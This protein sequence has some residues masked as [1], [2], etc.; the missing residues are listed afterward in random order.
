MHIPKYMGDITKRAYNGFEKYYTYDEMLV[1]LRDPANFMSVHKGIM[2][3]LMECLDL[4]V[5]DDK[6]VDEFKRTV[7]DYG[8]TTGEMLGF[9]TEVDAWF[10][11]SKLPRRTWAT[12]LCFAFHLSDEEAGHFLWKVCKLNGFC[13]RVAEDVIHCY[14]LANGKSYAEAKDI[15]SEYKKNPKYTELQEY[16]E[17]VLRRIKSRDDNYTVRTGE[18]LRAFSNL[19]GMDVQTFKKALFD[20]SKYFIGYSVSAHQEMVE[21]YEEAVEQIKKDR[22]VITGLSDT[23]EIKTKNENDDDVIKYRTM[24]FSTNGKF[25]VVDGRDIV[26][27]KFDGKYEF[28]YDLVW[29]WLAETST[30]VGKEFKHETRPLK[31]IS[32]V[33]NHVQMLVNALPPV[34]RVK[35]LMKTSRPE[36]AT[37]REYGSARMVFV[38]LYF[39]QFVLRWERYL[40]DIAEQGES[41]E[42]FFS[43]FYEGLNDQLESCGYS[44]LYY[45]NSFD[46]HILSCVRLLDI[47]S[48][49]D[50]ELS[51]LEQFNKAMAELAGDFNE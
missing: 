34:G 20:H 11:G 51:A 8:F 47:A 2:R 18:L 44:Y 19:K 17:T 37:D 5:G 45:A 12:R 16:R 46:W 49:D 36:F 31:P 10:N 24:D 21:K 35:N 28:S 39:A 23:V 48:G 43:E 9:D 22:P 27:K 50:G 29:Q 13:Y 25:N 42:E 3:D 15:V 41:P 38:F 1:F 7:R 32:S 6:V 4:N 40:Y 33:C 30:L 26:N 14:C